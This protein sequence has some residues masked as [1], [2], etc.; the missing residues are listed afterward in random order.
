MAQKPQNLAPSP[1]PSSP[2][3]I[4]WANLLCLASLPG[5]FRESMN[6]RRLDTAVQVRDVADLSAFGL[7][8]LRLSGYWWIY[9]IT[10]SSKPFGKAK[11]ST[12]DLV[13]A[14]TLK[15]V[16]RSARCDS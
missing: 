13:S 16:M 14:S 7:N 5:V 2:D 11:L 4:A 8:A 9:A 1:M 10:R 12:Q 3:R 6:A 15:I